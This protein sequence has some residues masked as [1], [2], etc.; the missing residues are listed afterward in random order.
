VYIYDNKPMTTIRIWQ[1]CSV[2]QI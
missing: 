2:R 1:S